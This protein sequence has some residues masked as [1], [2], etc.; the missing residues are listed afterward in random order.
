M[1]KMVN[2]K[3]QLAAMLAS[4]ANLD[5]GQSQTLRQIYE[6]LCSV[7]YEDSYRTVCIFARKWRQQHAAVNSAR[8]FLDL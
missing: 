8:S 2:H 1:P 3:D 7:G 5:R 4:N 6:A